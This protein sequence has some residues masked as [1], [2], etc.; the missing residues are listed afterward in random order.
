MKRLAVRLFFASAAGGAI[1]F[2]ISFLINKGESNGLIKSTFWG[3]G[4]VIGMFLAFFI[5][6]K[7]DKN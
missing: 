3:V 1:V 4:C 7:L 6:S 2:L 5:K